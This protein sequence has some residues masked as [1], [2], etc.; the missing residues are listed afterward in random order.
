MLKE[1]RGK[2]SPMSPLATVNT[3]P[4]APLAPQS[5]GPAKHFSPPPPSSY[6]SYPP[7]PASH[8]GHTSYHTNT[9]SSPLSALL[10]PGSHYLFNSEAKGPTV[11]IF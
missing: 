10:G 4:L 11:Q 8:P 3:A 5:P 2:W 9:F 1:D 7:P 6:S